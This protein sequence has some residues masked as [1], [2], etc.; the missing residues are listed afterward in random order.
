MSILTKGISGV[1]LCICAFFIHSAMA[2]YP[3]QG[4]VIHFR[5][6][7]VESPCDISFHAENMH[8]V[9]FREGKK[10][11]HQIDLR[12]ATAFAQDIES[13]ATVRFHYLNKQKNLAVMNI[14]YR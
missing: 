3:I 6:A 9:C 4:G 10:K 5:G 7:I 8:L 2:Q 1:S 14:E 12:Q 11:M 13:M